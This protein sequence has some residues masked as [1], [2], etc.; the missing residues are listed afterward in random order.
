MSSAH[1]HIFTY[2]RLGACWYIHNVLLLA[3]EQLHWSRRWIKQPLPI[4]V[5]T[6]SG[7]AS[8]FSML[9]LFLPY[10]FTNDSPGQA[11]RGWMVHLNCTTEMIDSRLVRLESSKCDLVHPIISGFITS[12]INTFNSDLGHIKMK[13]PDF[14]PEMS[15]LAFLF[16]LSQ[17]W[18][19]W[20]LHLVLNVVLVHHLL[21][22]QQLQ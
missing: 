19:T 5:F 15:W 17:V 14:H 12:V 11:R 3:S 8:G 21:H 18:I 7:S 6:F 16:D 9:S 1:I 13:S 22:A 20:Q 10:F 4:T 2:S